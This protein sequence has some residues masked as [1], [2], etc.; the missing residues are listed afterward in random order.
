[1]SNTVLDSAPTAA[2]G[3]NLVEEAQRLIPLL[4]AEALA[5]EEGRRLTPPVHQAYLRAG[6]Y[7]MTMPGEERSL[8]EIMRVLETLATGDTSAAWST[9]TPLGFPAASAFIEPAGVHELFSPPDACIVNSQA[10]MGRAVSVEGGYRVSGRWPFM[11]GIRQATDVSGTCLVYDGDTPRRGPD[12]EPSIVVPVWPVGD[13]T[14]IENWD[15]TGLRGTGSHDVRVEDLFVPA[16][17]V[18]DF[19]RPPRLEIGPLFQVHIDNAANVT[20]ASIALGTAR[21]ALDAFRD[22]APNKKLLEGGVLADSPQAQL[23]F[24]LA[25]T[26]LAQVRGHLYETAE[27]MW[28]SLL[29]DTYDHEAWF[30]RTA[31]ASASAVDAAIEVTISLYRIAATSA[32][33]TGVFDRAVRD[34]L[35][36]GAHKTVQQSNL[37]KHSGASLR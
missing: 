12:G 15:T 36:L 32:I 22:L 13:C 35:T 21:N 14:V 5:I 6:F 3:A 9:W 7:R 4:R 8:P 17:R 27:L 37:L 23:V 26:R 33:R 20:C 28:E 10:A 2:L 16:H 18:A 34:L 31:M 24:A 30:P 25:E 19:T 11:S 29:N 1:M